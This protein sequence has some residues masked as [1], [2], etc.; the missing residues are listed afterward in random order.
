MAAARK[1][2]HF[3]VSEEGDLVIRFPSGE[4]KEWPA[5][6]HLQEAWE[7]IVETLGYKLVPADLIDGS[8]E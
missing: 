2:V 7:E 5:D 1:T 6:T 3:D 8:D 4:L